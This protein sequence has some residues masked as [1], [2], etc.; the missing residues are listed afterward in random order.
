MRRKVLITVFASLALLFL[1]LPVAQADQVQ[2]FFTGNTSG[3]DS[4]PYQMVISHTGTGIPAPG[5]PTEW[6]NCDD[7]V[8]YIEGGE[9]WNAIVIQGSDDA[10]LVTTRMSQLNSWG[11]GQ[12][13]IAYDEK[14]WIELYYGPGNNPAYSDAIWHIF[15]NSFGCDA[16]C[17]VI[18]NAAEAAVQNP[19]EAAADYD[20]YRQHLTIYTPIQGT[21]NESPYPYPNDTPQEFDGVPDGGMTLMLLG[22]VLVG[23]EALRRKFRG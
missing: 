8:D 4:V 9:Y 11:V 12:A 23:L 22:G 14:A 10:D 19:T 6:L 16:N 21:E 13:E 3:G 18:L 5:S 1:L 20:T 15:D 2:L 7:H 17:Q